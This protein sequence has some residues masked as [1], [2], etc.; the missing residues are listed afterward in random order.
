MLPSAPENH[1]SSR[2]GIA[3]LLAASLCLVMTPA[4]G[5][6]VKDPP[7]SQGG[8]TKEDT[9]EEE[10]EEDKNQGGGND[11][12]GACPAVVDCAVKK[13]AGRTCGE[14][15]DGV[16]EDLVCNIPTEIG[17]AC[18]GGTQA[19][20]EGS[21]EETML[22]AALEYQLVSRLSGATAADNTCT[23]ICNTKADCGT[24]NGVENACIQVSP[25]ERICIQGCTENGG[26][27]G[28]EKVCVP[29]QDENRCLLTCEANADCRHGLTCKDIGGGTKVCDPVRC[30]TSKNCGTGRVC[31]ETGATALCVD[32]CSEGSCPT[33]LEC[34]ST[35]KVCLAPQGDY[36]NECTDDSQCDNGASCTS[37]NGANKV[38]LQSCMATGVCG[39]TPE[40]AECSV[41]LGNQQTGEVLDV[42]CA[43]PCTAE[44]TCPRLTECTQVPD[45]NGGTSGYC[46]PT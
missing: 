21:C 12:E 42:L 46:L 1:M 11:V 7:P 44:T 16:C 45:G 39:G 10:E 32:E 4:C 24:S 14:N 36:Y 3:G 15:N 27:C 6:D 29:Y 31:D 18:T 37:S 34:D 13:C 22:C 8:D 23:K 40:G 41:T 25:Q 2:L 5:G 38:C 9:K 35:S 26:E 43:L 20:P 19:K 17:D 30:P 28:D 33:G